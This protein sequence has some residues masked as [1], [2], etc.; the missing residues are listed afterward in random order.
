[1]DNEN[2]AKTKEKAML[3]SEVHSEGQRRALW[4]HTKGLKKVGPVQAKGTR[5]GEMPL[6]HSSGNTSLIYSSWKSMGN[7]REIW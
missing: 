1:M 5:G 6:A 3:P 7:W 2:E 4:G